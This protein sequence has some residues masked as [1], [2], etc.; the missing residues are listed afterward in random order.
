[1]IMNTFE[2]FVRD[3]TTTTGNLNGITFTSNT[4][5]SP[6]TT[7]TN[8]AYPCFIDSIEYII[9][10]INNNINNKNNLNNNKTNVRVKDNWIRNFNKNGVSFAI[11][12]DIKDVK[13]IKNDVNA[14]PVVIVLFKDGTEEKAVLADKDTFCLETGIG[15]CITK[16]LLSMKNN[17]NGGSALYNKIVDRAV[18][19][20]NRNKEAKMKEQ[21]EKDNEESRYKKLV[22]KKKRRNERRRQ[23]EIEE[24]AQYEIDIENKKEE[25]RKKN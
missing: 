1:M 10:T 11:I 22:E 21:I 13:V 18:K 8:S 24:I 2:N 3:I 12:P 6:N 7:T 15:I 14:K 23:K 4:A 25:L 17:G 16:K 19:V 9:D 5:Y 20:M